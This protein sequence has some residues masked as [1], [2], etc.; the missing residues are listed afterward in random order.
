MIEETK[1]RVIVKKLQ[2]CFEPN[3][4]ETVITSDE[5]LMKDFNEFENML[6]EYGV[7]SADNGAKSKWIIRL[8][9]DKFKLIE[10]NITL[11]DIDYCLKTIYHE[12]IQTIYSDYNSD[13]LIFRIR[14]E[15]IK[16]TKPEPADLDQSDEICYIKSFAEQLMDNVSLRGLKGISKVLLRK[17]PSYL[18]YSDGKYNNNH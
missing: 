5:N 7:T 14:P 2:I 15:Q 12:T 8:T 6:E 3:E 16:K 11:D 4:D 9:L 1:L 13:N 17:D 18:A 10:K